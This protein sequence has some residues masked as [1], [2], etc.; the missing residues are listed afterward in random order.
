[1]KQ[2]NLKQMMKEK[3]PGKVFHLLENTGKIAEKEG[4]SAY[5]VGGMVRDLLLG[6]ENLDIDITVE[7]EGIA[8]A[9]KLAK[10]LSGRVQGK[11]RFGTAVVTFPGRL[12]V[13]VATAR[14]EYYE[15]PAALPEVRSSSLRED[16]FRRDFTINAMS[17]RLNPEDFGILI[18]FFGG[19]KDLE[20]RIIRAL[21]KGSFL[22][23]PTRIFR[24]VRFA[25]RYRF[26]IEK[27]TETLIKKAVKLAMFDELTI[28]RLRD[29]LVLIFSEKKPL[30]AIEKMAEL[31]ELKFIHPRIRFNKGL[32]KLLAGVEETLIWFKDSFPNE[33]MIP[34]LIYFAAL[35]D[36]LTPKEVKTTCR[37][38]HLSRKNEEKIIKGRKGVAKRLKELSKKEELKPSR[39]YRQLEDLPLETLLLLMARTEKVARERIVFYLNE[40]R[41]IKS[42]V[43]GKELLELGLKPGPQFARILKNLLY[44]RL[45]GRVRTKRDE[46]KYVKKY[47]DNL[48]RTGQ[49]VN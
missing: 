6:V 27:R 26:K 10:R 25:E 3:L 15:H 4:Y 14:S 5:L 11:T 18:D 45:D 9:E 32:K 41:Q 42:K 16:Q 47:L 48:T 28:E 36:Q 46:M 29:E 39:I 7:G 38:F 12:K 24:A 23:D 31:H 49:T 37:R 20:K 22:D 34:W 30:R 2:E 21:H 8:F 44:A 17:I 13:D 19:R 33:K 40:L 35:L 1:M 43:S